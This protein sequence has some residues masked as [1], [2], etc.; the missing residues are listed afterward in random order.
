MK[1]KKDKIKQNYEENQ[2][3]EYS[4]T[5]EINS[6]SKVLMDKYQKKPIYERNEEFEKQKTDNIIRMRKEIE[7]EQ[8]ERCKPSINEKSLSNQRITKKKKIAKYITNPDTYNNINCID[9]INNGCLTERKK[10]EEK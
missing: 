3:K 9:D 5:P 1:M 8:K 10:S 4:F 7:K 6:Y 2:N